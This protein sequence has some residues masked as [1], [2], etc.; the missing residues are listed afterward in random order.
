VED[1]VST[2]ACCCCVSARRYDFGGTWPIC[3]TDASESSWDCYANM[4]FQAYLYDHDN[5]FFVGWALDKSWILC[6][7]SWI[8]LLL[9]GTCVT[10]A[11]FLLAPEDDYEM[12]PEPR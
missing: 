7:V 11:A 12:I 3:R 2:A 9:N 4:S 5:R 1:L 8:A 6:T 10:A